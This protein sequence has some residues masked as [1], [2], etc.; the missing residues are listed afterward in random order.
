MKQDKFTK[1]YIIKLS[2]SIII[3]ILNLVVQ[4]LLPRTFS[5]E[6]YGFYSYNLNMFTSIIAITN[7]STTNAMVSKFSKRNEEIGIVIFYLKFWLFLSMVLNIGVIFL[8]SLGPLKETFAHQTLII[9]LMSMEVAIVTRL[10]GDCIGIFDAMTI[11]RYPA[12]MQI[13][14]KVVLCIIVLAGYFLGTLNLL[15]F[16]GSQL[17]VTL[18][19]VL[20]MLKKIYAEQHRQ[21]PVVIDRGYRFYLKEYYIFCKPLVLSGIISQILV[22]FMNWALMKWSGVTEQAMFGAA[23]QLNSLVGYV[24]TPYADLSRREFAVLVKDT[25]QLKHRFE[26][27]LKIVMWLTCYFTLFIGFSTD[28]ILPIIY[29]DKYRG[30]EM[31]TLFIMFYT[32]YQAWGQICGSFFLATEQ[33][34]IHAI[35]GV[36]GQMASVGCVLLFQIPNP[37]WNNGLGA[38]GIALV[39]LIPNIISVTISIAVISYLSGMSFIKNES[40]Q[41]APILICGVLAYFLNLGLNSIWN[42]NSLPGLMYKILIS[43]SLYTIVIAG[44]IWLCPGFVGLS[45]KHIKELMTRKS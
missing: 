37:I 44:I 24:F 42:T 29:G 5:L 27:A 36:I 17:L 35:T 32:I 1:R 30:A 28:W 15:F 19:I 8:Y 6:E 22:I 20:I 21:F 41:I 9:V 16:Y 11:S 45:R 23:W 4:L 3:V 39:Y 7:L 34:R 26:Q 2:S 14:S 33:T 31:A 10:L 43:G 40:I 38:I 13:A 12:V 25:K 18:L